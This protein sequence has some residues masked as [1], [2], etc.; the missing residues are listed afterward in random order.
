MNLEVALKKYKKFGAI[1]LLCYLC[2]KTLSIT[3]NT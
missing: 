2:S 3:I 1:E